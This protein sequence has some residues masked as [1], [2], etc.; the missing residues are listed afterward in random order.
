LSEDGVREVM[1]VGVRRPHPNLM[2]YYAL[3]SLVLG[4][5]FPFWLVPRF[6]RFRT[7]RYTFDEEGVSMRWGVLFHRQVTLTYGRIQDIHLQSNFVERR[8]GLARV[9]IQT[10]AGSATA[11]MSID[12]LQEYAEV[13][14]Y[15]YSRMRGARRAGG[16]RPSSGGTDADELVAVL[17]D[18]VAEL[19]GL[20]ADLEASS[21]VALE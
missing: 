19:R 10:A 14:D 4:P 11:E 3:E 12:G 6:L 8:L 21:E 15:L 2:S 7:L 5:L 17:Q 9:K 1:V 18:V 13:R 16:A 20:R